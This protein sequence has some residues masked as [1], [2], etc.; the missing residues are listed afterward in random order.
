MIL[1]RFPNRGESRISEAGGGCGD[2]KMMRA[3][4]TAPS[5]AAANG[6]HGRGGAGVE[7]VTRAGGGCA[8]GSQPRVGG[9][10]IVAKDD[11]RI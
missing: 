4:C 8:C 6:L 1:G 9:E 5:G 7:V 2:W 11:H 10:R 3:R